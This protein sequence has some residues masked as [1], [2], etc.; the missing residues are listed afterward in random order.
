[1]DL[2]A[3]SRRSLAAV[4]RFPRWPTR[5]GMLHRR[6]ENAPFIAA[7]LP[8]QVGKPRK[9]AENLSRHMLKLLIRLIRRETL[10]Q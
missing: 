4:I 8:F 6:F 5:E 10:N 7:P 9:T 3:L 2:C 1:M